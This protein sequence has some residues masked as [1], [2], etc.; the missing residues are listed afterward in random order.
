MHDGNTDALRTHIFIVNY[1][2]R[3]SYNQ[4]LILNLKRGSLKEALENYILENAA[5]FCRATC[6]ARNMRP[7]IIVENRL[8]M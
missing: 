2:N 8:E 4:V 7:A 3:S 6:K 5:K 1:P